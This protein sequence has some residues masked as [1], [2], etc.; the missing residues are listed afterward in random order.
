[1]NTWVLLL[2]LGV[3]WFW[4]GVLDIINKDTI[5]AIISFLMSFLCLDLSLFEIYLDK[6]KEIR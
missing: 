5:A 1:M 3:C 6:G 4:L 2:I